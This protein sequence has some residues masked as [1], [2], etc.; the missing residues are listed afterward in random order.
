MH[1]GDL[2]IGFGEEF[3]ERVDEA[4]YA[5]DMKLVVT[6]GNHDNWERVSWLLESDKYVELPGYETILLAPRVGVVETDG[7]KIAHV[8]GAVSVDQGYRTEFIDWWPDED[9]TEGDVVS[10]ALLAANRTDDAEISLV[11]CHD[12]PASVPTKTMENPPN[13]WKPYLGKS[14]ENRERLETIV[15]TLIGNSE[16]VLVHGHYH[17]R[18]TERD[19]ALKTGGRLSRVEGLADNGDGVKN[20]IV[21]VDV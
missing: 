5:H 4:L 9:L 13:F 18:Y 3:L 11:V 1:A 15:S 17:Y 10:A 8:A 16:P 20:N 14:D 19:V 12:V 21:V 2:G 6:L 7:V